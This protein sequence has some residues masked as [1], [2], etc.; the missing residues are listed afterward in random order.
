MSF[1]KKQYLGL[2][3]TI[4]CMVILMIVL[5]FMANL[6][7][8]NMIEIVQDRYFKVSQATEVRQLFDQTDRQ[9][10]R[11]AIDND[12][13]DS[14]LTVNMLKDNHNEIRLRLVDI[15]DSVNSKTG[16]SLINEID[17]SYDAYFEMENQ[18]FKQLEDEDPTNLQEIYNSGR[19]NRDTLINLLNEFRDHQESLME[20]SLE[21]ATTTYSQL[22]TVLVTS[23]LLALLLIILV[24]L[25][26]IRST[27]RNIHS[28]TKGINKI[29]FEQLSNIPRLKVNSKDEIGEIALAFNSMASSLEQH[30][31]REQN[32]TKEIM[33]KNWVQTN[34]TNIIHL[35]SHHVKI[36]SLVEDLITNLAQAVEAKLG[37]FY[38]KE[39]GERTTYRKVA[40][41]ADS[42]QAAGKDLFVEGEGLVGQCALDKKIIQLNEIPDHSHVISTGLATIKPQSI[43]IAPVLLK[44][45]VVAVIELASLEE[46]TP[47]QIHLLE[48]VLGT[49]GIAITNIIGRMEIANLLQESQAKTEELQMQSE[50]LQTQSE[51]LQSQSEEM[52]TQAEE[53]RMI[54]EQLEERTKDAELK[55]EELQS[56]KENLEEK[57]KELLESS[58]YK[59]EFLAN[60][61]HELRTPLNSILLLSEMLMDDSDQGLNEEQVE[62]AKVIHSSGKDLL[63][64]INDI[65]D[66]SKVEVG[67]MDIHF[68]EVNILELTEH[69]NRQFTPFAKKKG[70]EFTVTSTE[71]APSYIYSDEQR[72]QQIIK[73]LLS[74]AFKFTEEGSVSIEI[75]GADREDLIGLPLI[76]QS[77]SWLKIIVSDTG[78]GI[79]KMKF[80]EIFEAFQ[81]VD[82]ATMRKYGGTG[83]GL[84][85]TKEFAHLLGGECRVISS[86]GKGSKFTL[87]IP[88]LPKGMPA[89]IETAISDNPPS[90]LVTDL[91]EQAFEKMPIED[92]TNQKSAVLKGKTVLVVDDDHRNIFAIKNAL[93]KEEMEVLT[94]EN[95]VDCLEKIE[96]SNQ[97]DIVLMDIMMPIMDGYETMKRIRKSENHQDVPIVAL[98]AKAMNSDRR[99]CLESGASDY[100]SKPLNLDQLLSV[101]RVWLS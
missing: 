65:L 58:K 68:E 6:M 4:F 50:E 89:N 94:A 38:L 71:N 85:I 84:S 60:M 45:E 80:D 78:I 81:Q 36:S 21:N 47:I 43:L 51:E 64:L 57:A 61:S 28:I 9:L 98:T 87:L 46:F 86:E 70:L 29:D 54:N 3:L 42:G 39:T 73:N 25:W 5:L 59:S 99:K 97:I 33:G 40:S 32:Y 91:P 24:T 22:V 44:D 75:E 1:K 20:D 2:G 93:E 63:D 48:E 10:L 76:D 30:H 67:K 23:V 7:R 52:Q 96:Q 83:L 16:K 41:F 35:Y 27:S 79:P 88:S 14:A 17:T 53:L 56:A 15:R 77:D 34:S 69:I 55:S 90:E 101:M 92:M 11:I 62:F 13:S 8:A 18:V 31:E 72:L 74:N 82:G 100:I 66:L 26:L 95:G 12:L 37:V 19:S 49:L